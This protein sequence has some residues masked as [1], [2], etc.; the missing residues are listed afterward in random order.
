MIS[1]SKRGMW[2]GGLAVGTMMASLAEG[3]ALAAQAGL[4][5]T[6]LLDVISLGAM[7]NPM[8]KLKV[9]FQRPHPKPKPNSS[10]KLKP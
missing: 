2:G 3:L 9:G 10:P 5:Q 1:T 6:E 4:S 8:F 7:A